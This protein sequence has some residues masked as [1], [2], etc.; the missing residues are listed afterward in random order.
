MKQRIN[1][2]DANYQRT[3]KGERND[4][5]DNEKNYIKNQLNK[6]KMELK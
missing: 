6:K 2:R 4:W 1:E 3:Y 5:V